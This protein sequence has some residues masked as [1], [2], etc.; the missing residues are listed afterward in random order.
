MTFKV[1]FLHIHFFLQK[2]LI[3][4]KLNNLKCHETFTKK[5]SQNLAWMPDRCQFSKKCINFLIFNVFR[6]LSRFFCV[7]YSI[8]F[9]RRE[10]KFFNI[11]A[12]FRDE[13]LKKKKQVMVY[14][15]ESGKLNG[16]KNVRNAVHYIVF[17]LYEH[18]THLL[19]E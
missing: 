2:K 11:F 8:S 4:G 3:D 19:Q 10:K 6:H 17:P 9:I 14:I 5:Y 16:N 13:R 12:V 18:I 7:S 15:S 1:S